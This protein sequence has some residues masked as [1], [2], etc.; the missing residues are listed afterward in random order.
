ME[1][2]EQK[3]CCKFCI[4]GTTHLNV[5]GDGQHRATLD[6]ISTDVDSVCGSPLV[7]AIRKD[8]LKCADFLV[9]SGVN[10]NEKGNYWDAALIQGVRSRNAEC[11]R[12]LLSSGAI[13]NIQ[14]C[15]GHTALIEAV[16]NEDYEC[17]D[18]LLR[19]GADLNSKGKL[20]DTP[21]IQ[22]IKNFDDG[23][24]NMLLD[25]GADVNVE[26]NGDYVLNVAVSSRNCQGVAALIR[27]GVDVNLRDKD[28][29]T[30]LIQAVTNGDAHECTKFLIEAGADVNM[31]GNKGTALHRAV[32]NRDYDCI[33]LLLATGADV[34]ATGSDGCTVP[35][36]RA[37]VDYTLTGVEPH[38]P[39]R[40]V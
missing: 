24:M 26:G 2:S 19:Y 6:L 15:G 25:T 8:H 39:T 17:I 34:N 38:G 7:Q 32:F 36:S 4:E 30:A 1:Y 31:K 3:R 28:G 27:A 18:L 22:A 9:Q 40:S 20:W 33:E 11:V 23:S 5:H 35:K 12:L 16:R 21:L 13:V 14:S 10:V 29:N 37:A